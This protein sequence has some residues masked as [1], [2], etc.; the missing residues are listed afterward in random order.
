MST[1][2]RQGTVTDWDDDRGFGFIASSTGGPRV[3]VHVSAVAGDRRPA[4]GDLVSYRE[5][6][7]DR[8]RP[9]AADVAFAA[10]PGVTRSAPPGLPSALVAAAVFL[11]LL[12][13]LRLLDLAPL[14][15]PAVYVLAS[16]VAVGLY[17]TDK[18]AARRGTRRVPES[19][20]HLVALLGGWPGALVAQQAFRHKTRKQ[21]FRTVFWGTVVVNCAALAW[22]AQH[23]RAVLG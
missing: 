13:T 8:G 5:G 10:S 14:L 3:F 17:R 22:L 4:V 18:T 12:V 11:G 9:R 16:T 21:P 7:D 19:T 23:M 2:R 1:T 15:L 20:L 6:S